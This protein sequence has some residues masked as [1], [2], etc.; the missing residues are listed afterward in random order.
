LSAFDIDAAPDAAP[1]AWREANGVPV[2]IDSLPNTIYHSFEAN[3]E[4]PTRLYQGYG[5]AGAQIIL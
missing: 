5:A 4:R 2:T 3:A 1:F